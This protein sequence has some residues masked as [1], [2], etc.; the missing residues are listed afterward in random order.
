MRK[1]K[2]NLDTQNI[3]EEFTNSG[4]VQDELEKVDI[5]ANKDIFYYIKKATNVIFIWNII[6]FICIIFSV[7][8]IFIQEKE[9]KQEYG[10]L[11][12]ICFLFLWEGSLGGNTCYGVRPILRE[13]EQK[14]KR[15]W[16]EQ[17]QRVLP[18]LE[19]IYSIE[20][21]NFSKRASFLLTKSE[22]RLE[23]LE[24]LSSFDELKTQFAPRDKSE[25]T[26]FNIA[27]SQGNI[28]ELTCDVFSSDWDNSIAF[29]EN[30]SI[31][32]LSWWG[33][34]IS[35]AGSF[36]DFIENYPRSPFTVLDKPT[37]FTIETVQNGP[38]T[39]KTT[40]QLQ[41]WYAKFTD[42]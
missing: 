39:K 22:Q 42:L 15:E 34:S 8:Y 30:G 2:E 14:L 4:A 17:T 9:A 35:R 40:I 13:Y 33:T 1:Q 6:L 36:I 11:S 24:I 27:I 29:L 7:F 3:F 41:L 23:P 10:F 12:P 32:S 28:L 19:E 38:Y 31:G 20:N 37:S 26:C 5:S 18:L 25:I 21:F 16:E